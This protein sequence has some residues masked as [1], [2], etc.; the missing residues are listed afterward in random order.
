MD[1]QVQTSFIPKQPLV[2]SGRRR[3]GVGLLLLVSILLF[4]LSVA[5]AGAAFGYQSILKASISNKDSTLKTA[6]G[7]FEAN[8][9]E[10]LIRL[11][12]RLTHTSDL[13]QKHIAPSGVFDFLSTI[14]LEKVQFTSFKFTSGKGGA[15]TIQLD[16]IGDSFSTVAL[17]SDQFGSTRL[18]KD[19]IFSD[20]TVGSGGKVNFRVSATLDP[21][22]YM[23]ALEANSSAAIPNQ[24]PTGSASSTG[25]QQT[26]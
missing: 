15:A 17:Q 21:T 12:N 24:A 14:T 25:A 5:G 16:G 19:V 7:A 2:E 4:V 22:L 6:E 26:Q 8:V 18:L 10:D 11:D 23:Y 1:P 9:I 13:L 3:L 20:V